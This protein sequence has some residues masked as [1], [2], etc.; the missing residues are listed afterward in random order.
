MDWGLVSFSRNGR[1]SCRKRTMYPA[2][3]YVFA[4]VINL[5]FRFSWAANRF[6]VFKQLH[7]SHLVLLVEIAEVVRRSLW[8]MIRIEW[9]V[10]VQQEKLAERDEEGADKLFIKVPKQP[11]GAL[12]SSI[13]NISPMA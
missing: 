6:T 9:E 5:V 1:V 8:N 10:L 2:I 12:S 4:F 11:G 13:T 7:A 3:F